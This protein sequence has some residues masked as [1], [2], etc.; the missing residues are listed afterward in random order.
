V[1]GGQLFE[2]SRR[3]IAFGGRLVV[4]GFTSGAI[5]TVP[6]NHVLLRN[7]SVV[8]IHLAAY[9]RADP[10][11]L[12]RVHAEVLDHLAAGRIAPVIHAVLPFE[13]LPEALRLVA[14]R[15]VIGRVALTTGPARPA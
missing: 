10:E 6:A 3:C 14:E 11:L 12:R 4:A 8:G 7:Y 1:V 13:A 15:R 2:H 5:P 9:R